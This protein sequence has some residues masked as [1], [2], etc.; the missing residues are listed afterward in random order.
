MIELKEPRR[1]GSVGGRV[2]RVVRLAAAPAKGRIYFAAR[3]SRREEL[4]A[5]AEQARAAGLEVTSRW[6]ATD[7]Q[8]VNDDPRAMVLF[9]AQDLDD[10]L[11]S[12]WVVTFTEPPRGMSTNRGGRHVEYGLALGLALAGRPLR[13]LVVGP[14]ENVFHALSWIP[15]FETWDKALRYLIERWPN[16]LPDA[17]AGGAR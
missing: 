1:L 15:R 17:T 16:V 10:L 5:Y 8:A 4:C 6:I 14:A 13:A 9:G 7:H 12:D 3:Y 11:R 2:R